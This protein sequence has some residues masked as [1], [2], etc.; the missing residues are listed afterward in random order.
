MRP[1]RRPVIFRETGDARH[2]FVATCDGKTW[3]VRI[4][5]F[6][7]EPSLYTLIVDGEEVEELIEW[8]EAWTR[9][10]AEPPAISPAT[11]PV[12]HA[13]H[14]PSSAAVDVPRARTLAEMDFA[15]SLEPCPCCGSRGEIELDLIGDGDRWTLSG[16]C[17][18]CEAPRAFTFRTFGDP[19]KGAYQWRHLGDERP[20]QILA[21]GQLI[22]EID[23]LLPRIRTEPEELEPTEW[24][25]STAAN[26]R[27]VTCLLELAKFL[28]SDADA[29]PD[30][31]VTAEERA[32]RRARPE[33][34]TR[35]WITSELD[36]ALA[37]SERYT[38]DAPRIWNLEERG[39][40]GLYRQAHPRPRRP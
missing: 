11:R 6:P 33:R 8:P 9:P 34:Y 10:R 31:A 29:I 20:S 7:A 28:P 22:A 19:L 37:L 13:A 39:E 26:E 35:S 36:R 38:A 32:A 40:T 30:V 15:A 21:P 3:T 2:P 23:R 17:P 4:N 18:R 16:K 27:R 14:A 1:S 24:R 12:D 5:E 25:A